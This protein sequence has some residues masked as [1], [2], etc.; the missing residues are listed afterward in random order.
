MAK[1]YLHRGPGAR[2]GWAT[3]RHRERVRRFLTA[4]ALKAA[5]QVI[6]TERRE[7]FCC[8][9]APP[10]KDTPEAYAAMIAPERAAIRRFDRALAKIDAALRVLVMTLV[11]A[12]MLGA[13]ARSNRMQPNPPQCEAAGK[14]CR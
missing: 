12:S 1:R 3:R 9:T 13:C 14:E 2:K 4:V 11:I 8:F 10:H 5:K 7:Q 6:A